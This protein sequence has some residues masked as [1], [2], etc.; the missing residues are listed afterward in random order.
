MSMFYK[1]LINVSKYGN[2]GCYDLK[3]PFPELKVYR[4]EEITQKFR[5]LGWRFYTQ[6]KPPVPKWIRI[7]LP[8]AL[9]L[10]L[11]MVI[12]SPIKFMI[13]GRWNYSLEESNIKTYNW[14]KALKLL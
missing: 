14:L 11:L 10:M 2:G 13:T 1:R 9:I 5:E 8:F 7:T 4:N 6:S 12:F 3:K